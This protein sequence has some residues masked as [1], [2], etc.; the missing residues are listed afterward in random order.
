MSSRLV[1]LI[2]LLFTV[3]SLASCNLTRQYV[4]KAE[5][6]YDRLGRTSTVV[7]T[8]SARIH[9]RW[10][11]TGKDTIVFIHGF[12]PLPQ[13]QWQDLSEV[14]SE[15]YFLVIPDLI[16]FE[17]SSSMYQE[18][19]PFFQSNQLFKA[20]KKA[21]LHHYYL[22][23]LSYG[24]LIAALMAGANGENVKGLILIDA[25]SKFLDRRHTDSLAKANGAPNGR[26]FLLPENGKQ[27]KKVFAVTYHNPPN[28]PAFLLNKPARML[29]AD[30]Q[31][32]KI[33]MINYLYDNEEE[34]KAWP[35]KYN[36]PTQ[37][38][39]GEHDQLIPLENAYALQEYYG[40][41][42]GLKILDSSAHVP[43]MEQPKE[44]AQTIKTFIQSLK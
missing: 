5:K 41:E 21:G 22:A 1:L 16:F 9:L 3:A 33:N 2:L 30:D 18:Y 4:R 26:K 13:V 14:L 10:L 37:V 7:E 20:L 8:D 35:V 42:T 39:W 11:G 23:G 27:L 28:Y 43:N 32:H 40:S 36:G 17:K 24:G 38:I 44:V 34:M 31:G 15:E 19:S 25:L 29:Y 12:G 6:S